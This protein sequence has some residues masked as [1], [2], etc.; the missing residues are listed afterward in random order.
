[1]NME[2]VTVK[3]CR[4]SHRTALPTP[5]IQLSLAAEIVFLLLCNKLAQCPG[6]DHD[7][8]NCGKQRFTSALAAIKIE[9]QVFFLFVFCVWLNDWKNR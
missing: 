8:V 6:S 2:L 5:A 9:K 3:A 1:M 7:Q 4:G